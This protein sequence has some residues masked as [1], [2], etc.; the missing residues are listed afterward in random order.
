MKVY[1]VESINVSSDKNEITYSNSWSKESVYFDDFVATVKYAIDL[2]NELKYNN[3]Y[4]AILINQ[5][6]CNEDVRSDHEHVIN[7]HDIELANSNCIFEIS[8]NSLK[9]K[10]ATPEG[11]NIEEK[12]DAYLTDDFCKAIIMFSTYDQAFNDIEEQEHTIQELDN[13]LEV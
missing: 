7:N 12:V 2:K 13:D 10:I 9:M 4:D 8:L 11:R 1:E 6:E 5:W 3:D